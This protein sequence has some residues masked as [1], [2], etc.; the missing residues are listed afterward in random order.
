VSNSP[1]DRTAELAIYAL[2]GAA[3]GLLW[4]PVALWL[5]LIGEPAWTLM[6]PA[7]GFVGTWTCARCCTLLMGTRQ[8]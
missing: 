4:L 8:P 6:L 5:R 1:W 3:C 2:A 7:L